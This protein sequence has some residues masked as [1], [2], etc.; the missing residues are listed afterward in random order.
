MT[1]R[2]QIP[3]VGHF[4]GRADQYRSGLKCFFV[5][6]RIFKPSSENPGSVFCLILIENVN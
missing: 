6:C 4:M 3:A 2:V 1:L 5:I